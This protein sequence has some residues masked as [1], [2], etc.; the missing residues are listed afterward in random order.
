[1]KT[2]PTKRIRAGF[3]LIEVMIALALVS[4]AIVAANMVSTAGLGI[5]RSTSVETALDTNALR[6]I[7]R[8]TFQIAKAD[9]ATLLPPE[10]LDGTSELAFQEVIG[11]DAGEPLWGPVQEV[12]LVLESAEVDD[13]LDNNGNDLVDEGRV[14]MRR[15]V[16]GPD[17]RTVVLCHG[18]RELL[19]GELLNGIDDNGNGLIDEPG[20]S[21]QWDEGV[22]WVRLSVEE[23]D[24]EG[25]RVVRTL[26]TSVRT[27]N[28]S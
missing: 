15:D 14:V 18:V 24:G 16:G 19:E 7:D 12:A 11:L 8:I 6:A 2:A 21:L 22:L 3:T 27:R 25:R 17:E 10:P 28:D 5:L 13:G 23:V 20:F 9:A 4:I 26:Q 1:M